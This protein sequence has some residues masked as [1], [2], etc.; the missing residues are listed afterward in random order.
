MMNVNRP[1]VA[2]QASWCKITNRHLVTRNNTSKEDH[3]IH[4]MKVVV[5]LLTTPI[6]ISSYAKS[7]SV[8][9]K[10][11]KAAHVICRCDCAKHLL[12]CLFPSH[13]QKKPST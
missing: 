2:S 3:S 6:L 1:L 13:T 11:K 10:L 9:N 7:R 8:F 4:A 12:P 5:A